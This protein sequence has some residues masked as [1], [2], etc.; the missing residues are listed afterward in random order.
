MK[1]LVLM[2]LVISVC[3]SANTPKLNITLKQDSAGEQKRKEQI[4]RLATQYDLAK[5]TITR[6]IVIDQQAM[7]KT[8]TPPSW[9]IASRWKV[10]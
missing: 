2:M 10:F 6:D 4:E 7:I 5:Y 3:V 1:H 9:T 8:F